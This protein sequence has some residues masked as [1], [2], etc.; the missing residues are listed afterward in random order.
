MPPGGGHGWAVGP[1]VVTSAGLG[2][3]YVLRIWVKGQF[4]ENVLSATMAHR[5][6]VPHPHPRLQPPR[7]LSSRPRSP[8]PALLV[9]PDLPTGFVSQG[10]ESEFTQSL[11][12][13]LL[14]LFFF[15]FK[16]VCVMQVPND[17]VGKSEWTWVL[18][19]PFLLW[20]HFASPA[21]RPGQVKSK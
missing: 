15:N 1:R 19:C 18:I 14:L 3:E 7:L 4:L 16:R 6:F 9:G 13:T 8:S 20:R 17:T 2:C 21:D 12:Q 5:L 11:W 10:S